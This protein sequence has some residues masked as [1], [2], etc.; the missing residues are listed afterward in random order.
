MSNAILPLAVPVNEPVRSYAPGSPEKKS[1]TARLH[2]M[3]SEQIEIP[4]I[5]GGKEVRSGDIGQAVCPHDH[6]H[7][8]ATFHT[9]GAPEVAAAAAA[10]K[11]AWKGWSETPWEERASLL[12]RAADLLAGPWRDTVNAATMLG[13]SKTAFQ[14]EIDSACEL[15]DFWRFNPYFMR[16][17]YGEQPWSHPGIWNRVEYRALEGFVFAV[18]PFNFTA[19]G[20][21]LPTS[22]ALMGNTVLW[23]PA[24]TSVLSNYY[25][26]KALQAAGLPDGVI[27]FIPGRAAKVGDPALAHPDFA[28]I[29]FTGSTPVFQAMWKTMAEN[30]PRYRSY[31]R[32]VGETGGKNFIFAHPSANVETLV[33]A[34]LR[35][36]FE[37]QGQKCSAGSRVYVPRSLWD[38]VRERLLDEMKTIRMGSPEDFRNFVAAVIDEPSFDRIMRY[39]DH[40]KSSSEAEILAGGKGD[41]SEGYFIEPTIVLTTNPRF[42]LMQEEIFGPVVTVFVYED[43]EIEATL[44]LV[45]TTSPYALTGAVFA[46][47]R[48]AVEHLSK[49]FRHTAGNFYINDKPTG[50]VVGQQPFGGARASGTNDKAGSMANLMRWTSQR[51]IKETFV[52]A[53][54]YRYP[55]LGEK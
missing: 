1:L 10:A 22:P 24:S 25:V 20:G 14:A 8:L 23:K 11:E 16:V 12:L 38:A 17:L 9:A 3:G 47:D 54:D 31:P 44:E 5:I 29:H 34:I 6:K 35:G 7:V 32:I 51:A 30:I 36:G 15:I 52:P 45:D 19:I 40:A 18:S 46:D 27:N 49:A 48:K 43:A 28:G 37:Y 53:R 41:K 13:Q 26:M 39:I 4:L 33:A 42:K 21:N 2:E 50:A 55:F